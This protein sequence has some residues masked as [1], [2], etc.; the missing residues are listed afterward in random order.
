MTQL[1]NIYCDESCHLEN[2]KSNVM[3]LGAVTC[4]DTEKRQI[5]DD[6]R[7]IKQDNGFH[8]DFEIKWTKVSDKKLDFYID[9][10]KY[11][12]SNDKLGFRALIVPDKSK[13]Q[14]QMFNQDWDSFYYKMYYQM[15]KGI[16]N[17]RNTYNI[18]VDIKDTNG[19]IKRQKLLEVLN[20]LK[21]DA[22][23]NKQLPINYIQ[24]VRS[25]EIELIQ[26]ADLL[27][28]A[29]CYVNRGLGTSESKLKIIELLKEETSYP[30]TAT[31]F[32]NESKFNIFKIRLQ[33]C[34][35]F[36]TLAWD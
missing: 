6:I 24:A 23:F 2:D 14:N 19:A 7:K 18:F 35:G 30:L 26:L 33:N 1:I 36:N 5:F 16:L 4:P 12:L 25:H 31:T 29:V 3:V 8:R 34:G 27:I 28:G 10:V 13:V 17:P 21:N 15:L 22:Q 11:F 32:L 9:L 20:N